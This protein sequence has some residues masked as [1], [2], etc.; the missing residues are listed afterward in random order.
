MISQVDETPTYR[1]RQS[2]LRQEKKYVGSRIT[3][4]LE[5]KKLSKVLKQRC[6][7]ACDRIQQSGVLGQVVPTSF[8]GIAGEVAQ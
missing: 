6:P 8:D 1:Q 2:V 3:S 4:S 7:I 5:K